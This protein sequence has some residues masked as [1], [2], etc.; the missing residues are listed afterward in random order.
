M[1]SPSSWNRA[2]SWNPLSIFLVVMTCAVFLVFSYRLVFRWILKAIPVRTLSAPS[3]PVEHLD[4]SSQQFQVIRGG[5]QSSLLET[6]PVTRYANEGEVKAAECVVCLGEFNEG[7]WTRNLPECGHRFHVACID[8][9]F[10][11][12]SSCPV[13]RARVGS[14]LWTLSRESYA[15]EMAT[16][17]QDLS[18]R[19]LQGMIIN[20]GRD[21]A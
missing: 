1:S 3:H 2:C 15:Q 12:H 13:C 16:S 8:A 21:A 10:R 11:S 4:P 5:L 18:L 9:W 20:T 17:Y 19:I 6:L 14:S 7:E